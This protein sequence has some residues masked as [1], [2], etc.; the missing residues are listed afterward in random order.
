MFNRPYFDL[1]LFGVVIQRLEVFR[2]VRVN[3]S[4]KFPIRSTV[5]IIFI[6]NNTDLHGEGGSTLIS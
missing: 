4:L 1:V 3:K 2:K 6:R 5:I